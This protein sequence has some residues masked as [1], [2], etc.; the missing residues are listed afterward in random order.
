[1]VSSSP[2][3]NVFPLVFFS[4]IWNLEPKSSPYSIVDCSRYFSVSCSTNWGGW[5]SFLDTCEIKFLF[6]FSSAPWHVLSFILHLSL[7][8]YCWGR[9]DPAWPATMECLDHTTHLQRFLEDFFLVTSV[10]MSSMSCLFC[11]PFWYVCF[12]EKVWGDFKNG[13]GYNPIVSA[14]EIP[15]SL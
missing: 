3:P 4:C 12:Y 1:M 13:C 15:F 9:G 7:L 11:S 2:C 5:A 6:F 10:N 8:I 14:S